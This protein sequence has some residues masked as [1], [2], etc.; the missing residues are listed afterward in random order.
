MDTNERRFGGRREEDVMM[1]RT[2][3]V[4]IG[5]W[6]VLAAPVWASTG[7]ISLV[8]GGKLK[9]FI[10]TNITFMTSSSASGAA[11]EASYTQSVIA[12]TS[13]GG[14]QTIKLNDAFDG[15]YGFNVNGTWYFHN[16]VATTDCPGAVSGVDRQVVMN[17]QTIGTLQVQRKVYVPDDD[18]FARFLN[19]ITSQDS[20]PQSVNVEMQ[21]NLGS[22]SNTKIF[23]TSDGNTTVETT[24]SWVVSYQNFTGGTTSDP[25]LGHLFQTPGA[26]VPVSS[27]DLADGSNIFHW[28]YTFELP[29]GQTAIIAT[30][31][32]GQ[33]GRQAAEDKIK[34]LAA[35]PAKVFKCMSP[36]EVSQTLNVNL[37]PVATS[38]TAAPTPAVVGD[39][40]TFTGAANDAEQQAT[41]W[42]WNF[43]DGQT[44]SGAT[45]THPYAAAGVYHPSGFATDT[46][47]AASA[48]MATNDVT[49]LD[50]L[51]VSKAR[52][53]LNFAKSG[54]DRITLAG[55]V[56]LPAGFAP[57][58]KT[59]QLD[60]GGVSTTFTLN[61]KGTGSASG[62]KLK[63]NMKKGTFRIALKGAFAAALASANLTGATDVPKPGQPRSVDV[64]LT[65]DGAAR[66]HHEALIY[67]VKA[68][69]K[70][71]AKSS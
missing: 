3:G 50:P 42:T 49:V 4:G 55:S 2:L 41:T 10:N 53:L 56:P 19:I 30:F 17:P 57:T 31:V 58:G 38:A 5:L 51:D 34:E 35:L 39:A 9:F 15:Y 26:R 1:R 8:D 59:V 67:V 69:K 18:S 65:M 25:R 45:T 36:T 16:G 37:P 66:M 44:G 46:F 64:M 6:M 52:I 71:T 70:G 7:A 13:G 12:T 23:S 20:A 61:K 24:D 63:L 68:G 27:N 47:G 33:P 40:V 11:S 21:A 32:T 28:Y 62:G 48:S 43:G 22:D 54:A 14:T 60:V 29:P